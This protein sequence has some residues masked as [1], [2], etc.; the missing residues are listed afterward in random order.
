ML[1]LATALELDGDRPRMSVDFVLPDGVV[2]LDGNSLGAMPV[3]A[4]ERARRVVE[5]EWAVGLIR[6][7]NEA[8]WVSLARQVGDRIGRLVGAQP[9]TV[10]ACDSTSVNLYKAAGSAMSHADGPRVIL[11]DSANFPS[12]LYVLGSIASAR[13]WELRTVR[14]ER[15]VDALAD[16]VGVLAVTQVDYRSGRRHDM[17][18]VTRRASELGVVTVWDLAHSA[19]AFDVQLD[20][21]G[22]DYAVGCGYKFLNGGPGAPA[23]IYVSAGRQAEMSNPITG[24][25]G[26]ARPFDFDPEFR[27]AEGI[28]RMRVGTSHVLSLS[29]LDAALD[30]FDVVDREEVWLRGAGLVSHLLDGFDALGLDVITPRD[31]AERGSQASFRHPLSYA[32]VQA[33]IDRGVIGDF[34]TPDVARFGVAPLYS[35]HRDIAIALAQL[36]DVLANEDLDAHAVSRGEVT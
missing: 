19:G 11:T 18:A 3:Q 29:V 35:S 26:H 5:E 20:V 2:Y 12:D 1:D 25:F 30:T 9:G 27:P 23:F 13:G 15:V 6:S 36:S 4:R 22:V 28:D 24:W 16:G 17:E 10:I 33:L 32:I 21:C 7:W 34:R 14:P 8:D 31:P